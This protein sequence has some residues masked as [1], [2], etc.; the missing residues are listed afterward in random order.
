[1]MNFGLAKYWPSRSQGI[2]VLVVAIHLLELPL[3]VLCGIHYLADLSCGS[4]F[5]L[6]L[7]PGFVDLLLFGSFRSLDVSNRYLNVVFLLLLL[8]FEVFNCLVA[9]LA[10]HQV[11]GCLFVCYRCWCLSQMRQGWGKIVIVPP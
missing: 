1:M 11:R 3:S 10:C 5:S 7:L 9:K 8:L 2:K 4:D 6:I